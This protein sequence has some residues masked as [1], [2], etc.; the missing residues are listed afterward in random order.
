M[1]NVLFSQSIVTG[2][3]LE[4]KCFDQVG[5]KLFIVT[6][7]GSLLEFTMEEEPFSI[8]LVHVHKKLLKGIKSIKI[9]PKC[10]SVA[11]LQGDGLVGLIDYS[12]PSANTVPLNTIKGACC[13]SRCSFNPELELLAVGIKRGVIIFKISPYEAAE[14]PV[15]KLPST[16]KEVQFISSNRVVVSTKSGIYLVDYEENT[17]LKLF[18]L[19]SDSMFSTST[20]ILSVL[21]NW[22][23][24]D[25]M[26][27]K[28]KRDPETRILCTVGGFLGSKIRSMLFSFS[29]LLRE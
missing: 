5:S 6:T 14:C 24:V 17:S 16:P 8:T 10:Q 3:P 29:K 9:M 26:Q 18:S 19:P 4:I 23:P 13:I 20:Y 22:N 21:V 1:F 28:S 12:T 2:F 27:R 25:E 11:V 7:D 15:V